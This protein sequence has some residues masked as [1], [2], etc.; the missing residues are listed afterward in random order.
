MPR[1]AIW[2][3]LALALIGPKTDFQHS[4]TRRSQG[5]RAPTIHS[6]IP[7]TSVA[8]NCPLD[9]FVA[10]SRSGAIVTLVVEA[11][12]PERDQLKYKY[13][14]SVG[15]I[16]GTGSIA[17]WDLAK[18]APGFQT[19]KVEVSDQRGRK[20]SSTAQ[21][22]IEPCDH[23][24]LPCPSI[25]VSCPEKVFPGEIVTFVA[26]IDGLNQ[27]EK[28]TFL[29]NHS[30]GKRLNGA[31]LSKLKVEAGGQPGDIITASVR[32]RGLDPTCNHQA[33]CQTLVAK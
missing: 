12:D 24:Y 5:N 6:F 4:K 20:T 15:V 29:W 1:I 19:A 31:D 33:T 25:S 2:T 27:T 9:L 23:C 13:S 26:S 22:K 30:N 3:M 8:H 7:S 28:P 11:S 21:V 17:T 32:I 10:C 16:A 18:A 14:A